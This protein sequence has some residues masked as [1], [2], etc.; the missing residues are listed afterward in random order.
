MALALGYSADVRWVDE[1]ASM[2]DDAG[3]GV[4]RAAADAICR[5]LNWPQEAAEDPAELKGRILPVL[6][7]LAALREAAGQPAGQDER[8]AEAAPG[9]V[10]LRPNPQP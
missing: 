9:V 6:E 3:A 5:L 2:L 7:A 1:L 10:R 8:G 4:S